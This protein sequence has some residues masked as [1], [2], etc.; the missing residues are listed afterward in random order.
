[1]TSGIN[2]GDKVVWSHRKMTGGRI[3]Y[4][5]RFGS[6]IQIDGSLATVRSRGNNRKLHVTVSRLV[7]E[8]NDSPTSLV[9]RAKKELGIG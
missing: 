6:V 1:M 2:V 3:I 9:D 7:R 5:K 4:T 8:E